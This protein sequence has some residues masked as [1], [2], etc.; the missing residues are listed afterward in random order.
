[1]KVNDKPGWIVAFCAVIAIVL[2]LFNI[3]EISLSRDSTKPDEIEPP[4]TVFK[5][6]KD[7][8]QMKIIPSGSFLMGSPQYEK[9]RLDLEEPIHSVSIASFALGIYEVTW[10]EYQECVSDGACEDLFVSNPYADEGWGQGQRPVININLNEKLRYIDWLSIKSGHTYR[11][12]TEA[13]W[14][15]SARAGTQTAFSFGDEINTEQANYD[16]NFIYR[17][18]KKGVYRGRTEVVGSFPPNSFGIYDMHG[19]VW[20]NTSDCFR[21]Y[22][23]WPPLSIFEDKNCKFASRS[24]SWRSEPRFVRSAWRTDGTRESRSDQSGFRVA[25]SIK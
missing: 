11:L 22:N 20:E 8:P 7:C 16:G 18:G 1:M 12:P 19:N 4:K 23:N 24:G 14:E 25:R 10:S 13:E 17:N 6:C 3:E 15:C 21:R 5:D 2:G 9:G